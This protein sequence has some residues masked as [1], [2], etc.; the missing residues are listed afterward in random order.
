[1]IRYGHEFQDFQKKGEYLRKK[2]YRITEI[3]LQ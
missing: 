3:H 1:M 2:S